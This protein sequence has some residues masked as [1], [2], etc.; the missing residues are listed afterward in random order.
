[1]L[2][3]LLKLQTS[4]LHSPHLVLDQSWLTAD[5]WLDIPENES[6][7]VGKHKKKKEKDPEPEPETESEKIDDQSDYDSGTESEYIEPSEKELI[8]LMKT[9]PLGDIESG[10]DQEMPE[11]VLP[12]SLTN[13]MDAFWADHAPF[14]LPAFSSHEK[15]HV[16]NWSLWGEPD[17]EDVKTFGKDVIKTR[18]IE[19]WL[20]KSITSNINTENYVQYIGIV[21]ETPTSVTIMVR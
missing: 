13:F 4:I 2:G 15:D 7:V 12:L 1:M 14:Y 19:K 16:V 10:W 21:D 9:I 3:N 17:K 18:R 6:P 5:S 20:Y 8:D 11:I